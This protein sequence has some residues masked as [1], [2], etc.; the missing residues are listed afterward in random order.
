[1]SDTDDTHRMET[2]VSMDAAL[3]D[4]YPLPGT[5][6]KQYV[7]DERRDAAWERDT[8]PKVSVPTH[9]DNTGASCGGDESLWIH[10]FHDDCCDVC[11]D[12]A[13]QV[14]SR[15]DIMAWRAE[16]DA[17]PKPCADRDLLSNEIERDA[18]SMQD[19]PFFAFIRG[20]K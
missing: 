19:H 6:I 8:C 14:A 20:V 3:K 13:E 9:V 7:V 11:S 15:P 5:R 18:P 17:R 1:M 2:L 10:L 12:A 16:R 4:R